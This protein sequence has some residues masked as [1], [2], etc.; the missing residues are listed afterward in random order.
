[1][2]SRCRRSVD[3]SPANCHFARQWCAPYGESVKIHQDDS[4]EFLQRFGQPI[5]V[6]Y[7]D[8]LDTNQS[9][10]AVHCLKEA[11]AAEPWLSPEALVAIDDSPTVNGRVTGKGSLTVPWLV[12]R[13]FDVIHVGYQVVLSR[14]RHDRES[15]TERDC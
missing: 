8:S 12:S 6:L 15:A 14:G 11:A 1:M 4:V 5:D 2:Y 3:S 10:H 9:G 7:L 13:G